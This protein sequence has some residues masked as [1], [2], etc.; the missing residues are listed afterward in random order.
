M[1]H[2]ASSR[3]PV[4]IAW[5]A[6]DM[7]VIRLNGLYATAS[8]EWDTPAER[9]NR[10]DQFLEVQRLRRELCALIDAEAAGPETAA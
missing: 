7:A 1:M 5:D 9:K 3:T 6:F 8:E 10:L 2:L 4:E